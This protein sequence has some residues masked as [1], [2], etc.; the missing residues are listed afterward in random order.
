MKTVMSKLS[1]LLRLGVTATA[2]LLG[3]QALALGTDAGTPV[4]N[5]ATVAY[6]VGGAAQTPIE[7]DPLGNS[8]PGLGTPTT[9]LV[10]RRVS[11][12]LAPTDAVHTPVAPGGV[13]VFAAYTLTNTGNAIMDFDRVAGVERPAVAEDFTHVRWVMRSELAVG[14]QGTARFTAVLD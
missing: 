8:T 2:M 12:T 9:F 3:Q 4:S 7:S 1:L 5:Q 10:D 14:A 11:F 6:S 13:D